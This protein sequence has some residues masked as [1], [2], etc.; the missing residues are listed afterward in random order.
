MKHV[1]VYGGKRTGTNFLRELCLANLMDTTV[2]GGS[3]DWKHGLPLAQEQ[4]K[5]RWKNNTALHKGEIHP[6]IIIKN[7]YSWWVS[8]QNWPKRE[9]DSLETIVGYSDLYKRYKEFHL[10][11][12][13]WQASKI[14]RYED[15]L[16]D[17]AG[18]LK[19]IASFIGTTLKDDI[20]IPDKVT[21]SEKFTIKRKEFYLGNRFG[22]PNTIIKSITDDVDWDTIKYYGYTPIT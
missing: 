8:I 22:L 7:P 1:R 5:G 13:F 3:F 4:I 19:S 18:T 6:L 16:A 21:D 10:N 12:E 9:Y 15:L 20:T 2:Y 17:T 14:V 11:H